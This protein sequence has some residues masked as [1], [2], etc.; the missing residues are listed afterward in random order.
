MVSLAKGAGEIFTIYTEESL[1]ELVFSLPFFDTSPFPYRAK[2][3][4]QHRT[5]D[6]ESEGRNGP[7]HRLIMR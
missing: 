7:F 3:I 6:D 4:R 1:V 5:S 2:R